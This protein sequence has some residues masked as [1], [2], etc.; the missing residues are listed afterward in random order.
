MKHIYRKIIETVSDNNSPCLL[1]DTLLKEVLMDLISLKFEN[2]E[3]LNDLKKLYKECSVSIGA[4]FIVEMSIINFSKLK[5]VGEEIPNICDES[6][7]S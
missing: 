5:F 2:P 1:D 4:E 7:S 6:S 3:E